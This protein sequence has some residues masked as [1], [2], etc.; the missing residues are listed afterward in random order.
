L[1]AFVISLVVVAA[2]VVVAVRIVLTHATEHDQ[3]ATQPADSVRGAPVPVPVVAAPTVVPRAVDWTHDP[4]A[5]SVY[6]RVRS[7]V[8]LVVI[9]TVLGALTALLLVIG[10]AILLT[11]VRNAVQ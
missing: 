3:P 6:R 2:A 9:V 4:M 5:P 11:G 8:L 10:G 7:A 1:S